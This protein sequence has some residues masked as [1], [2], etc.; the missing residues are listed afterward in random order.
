M[1]S[2]VEGKRLTDCQCLMMKLWWND[3][4][5]KNEYCWILLAGGDQM[6]LLNVCLDFISENCRKRRCFGNRLSLEVLMKNRW[7]YFEK[8]LKRISLWVTMKKREV[9]TWNTR[10]NIASIWQ[11]RLTVLS[12]NSNSN[13]IHI[14]TPTAS[15]YIHSIFQSFFPPFTSKSTSNYHPLI[16]GFFT[17]SLNKQHKKPTNFPSKQNKQWSTLALIPH[18]PSNS[19][20]LAS[21]YVFIFCSASD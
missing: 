10:E 21:Q 8:Q 19:S 11:Y 2:G 5:L 6:L 15:F 18:K 4:A 14:K 1:R 20:Q 3:E 7:F 16:Q 17:V 12:S 13:N 9:Q